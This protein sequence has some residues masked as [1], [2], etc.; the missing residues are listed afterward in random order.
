[1]D[2]LS[3][4]LQAPFHHEDGA[5]STYRIDF[6]TEPFA[7]EKRYSIH[8]YNRGRCERSLSVSLRA[9]PT[10]TSPTMQKRGWSVGWRSK[11]VCQQWSL[12]W[13]CMYGAATEQWGTKVSVEWIANVLTIE[14]N[15]LIQVKVQPSRLQLALQPVHQI[16]KSQAALLQLIRLISNTIS[17][18]KHPAIQQPDLQAVLHLISCYG[19]RVT[20]TLT[21]S[22]NGRFTLDM[23]FV[24]M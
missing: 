4:Y 23:T 20:L 1:M 2:Q 22:R 15:S 18:P 21:V 24:R 8:H 10:T 5:I 11:I 19:R 6:S 14:F 12:Y 3:Q 9:P 16:S 13:T 7:Q 17:V